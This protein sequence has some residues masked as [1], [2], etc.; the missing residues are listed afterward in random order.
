MDAQA[1]GKAAGD[2][3][4]M[5]RPKI[6]IFMWQVDTGYVKQLEFAMKLR[7]NIAGVPANP[8]TYVFQA[9]A[10]NHIKTPIMLNAVHLTEEGVQVYV[11]S[12]ES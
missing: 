11:S 4:K 8:L 3:L 12:P 10:L 2:S 5:N 6:Q 9:I 7:N 1:L